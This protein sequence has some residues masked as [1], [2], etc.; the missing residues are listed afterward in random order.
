MDPRPAVIDRRLASVD[1]ILPV[2]GGKGGIGK[3]S[4][5]VG[6]ALAL[7]AAGARPGLL[8]L[9]LSGPSDHVILG[10][11]RPTFTEVGGLVPM[12]ASGIEFL[13][14]VSVVGERPAPLRGGDVSNAI[15][16]LLAVTRWGRL[17]ALIIDMPP[18]FGDALLD[19][20]RFVPRAE[21]LVVATPSPLVLETTRKAIGLLRQLGLPIAGVI[22]NLR[23]AGGPS[24]A[25]R[26]SSGEVPILG[27]VG[28]DGDYEAAIGDPARLVGTAF[29]RDV[30]GIAAS[31]RSA[32]AKTSR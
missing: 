7:A 11:A 30:T 29:M 2:S 13:S 25:D 24:I 22:E 21:H 16:E 23:L 19:I 32:P 14:I 17:D 12:T 8:D 5:S 9:D 3:S 15:L 6:L 10:L 18:G 31:L 20:A 1:R 27:S 28:Y 26:L 4:I